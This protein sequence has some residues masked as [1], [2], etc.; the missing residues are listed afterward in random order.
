VQANPQPSFTVNGVSLTMVSSSDHTDTLTLN[1]PTS[2]ST[3]TIGIDNSVISFANNAGAGNLVPLTIDGP[4]PAGT[5]TPQQG[6]INFRLQPGPPVRLKIQSQ[7]T[8][9]QSYELV[10]VTVADS[11]DSGSQTQAFHLTN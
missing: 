11:T 10:D 4:T 3:R 9:R 8:L 2:S 7:A 5:T 6:I 1:N